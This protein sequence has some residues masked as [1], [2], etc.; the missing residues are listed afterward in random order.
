M[1]NQLKLISDSL[2]GEKIKFDEMVSDH[3]AL[4]L[5]GPAKLFFVA[6]TQTEIKKIVGMARELKVPFLIFGS[7][8][9][10]I[11]S[12]YGFDGVVIKNRTRNIVVVGVK[13]KVLKKGIGV[14]E[15][16]VEVESG[17]FI[18]DLVEFLKKQSL[19]TSQIDNLSGTVG[20]NLFTSISLQERVQK[21]KVLRED[22][23][24]EINPEELS[25]GR[26]IILSSVFKFKSLT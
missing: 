15:V 22:E 11:V 8:S 5:G 25:L 18:S 24:E 9:K 6:T 20:G 26:H 2:G 12:E 21:I 19:N 3:T 7:G 13:G 23:L 17:V 1:D 10:M 16:S 4:K 14:D